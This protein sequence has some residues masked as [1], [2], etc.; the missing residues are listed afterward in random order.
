MEIL[1]NGLKRHFRVDVGP[2]QKKK[3]HTGEQGDPNTANVGA[4]ARSDKEK[5]PPSRIPTEVV[6]GRDN[7]CT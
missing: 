4:Q 2:P 6:R 5:K 7:S 3:K 1:V